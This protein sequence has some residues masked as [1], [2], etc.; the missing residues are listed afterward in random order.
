MLLASGNGANMY[1]CGVPTRRV[2]STDLIPNSVGGRPT[3]L[4]HVDYNLTMEN[5]VYQWKPYGLTT[6]NLPTLQEVV[7][8]K[9]KKRSCDKQ[10][11]TGCVLLFTLYIIYYTSLYIIYMALYIK[12]NVVIVQIASRK[13]K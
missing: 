7:F 3:A 9:K 11:M 1:P 12:V 8:A 6:T 5:F 2:G 4:S 13:T 10:C